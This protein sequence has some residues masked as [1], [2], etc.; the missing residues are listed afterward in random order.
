MITLIL[1][2]FNS[3]IILTIIINDNNKQDY[4]IHLLRNM[5]DQLNFTESPN[6]D[7]TTKLQRESIL[8]TSCLVRYADCLN[9]S[10]NLFQSWITEPDKMYAKFYI[11]NSVC[12]KYFLG[13]ILHLISRNYYS[14]IYTHISHIV[15]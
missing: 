3:T 8:S 13:S 12:V 15:Q 4:A 14:S 7:I 2:F 10:E 11:I 6:E 1:Q 5:Y 9:V